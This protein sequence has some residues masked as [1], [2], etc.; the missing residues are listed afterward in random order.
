MI[1]LNYSHPLTPAHLEQIELLTGKKIERVVEVHSQI[2]SQQPLAPQ[3]V[4]LADETKLTP[5]EWQSEE[6]LINP[7][8]LN[9]IAMTLLAEV[10]GRCGY[11]PAML[12]T[13]PVLERRPDGTFQPTTPPRYEPAEVINLQAVRDEARK[14]R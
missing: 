11:F 12:R 1:L 13:R 6:L 10:H 7:P 4:A 8:S 14:R 9:F 2:D 5:L 3:V